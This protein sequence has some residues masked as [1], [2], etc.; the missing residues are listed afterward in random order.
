MMLMET[1]NYVLPDAIPANEYLTIEGKKIS[2]S[3][4]Y[5]IWLKD[6]LENF[7][8]DPLRYTLAANAPETKDTDF[9]WAQFQNRNNDELADI[10]GNFINR[11]LIFIHRYYDGCVSERNKLDNLDEETVIA[12][13]F[14]Q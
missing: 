3:Q 1:G 9:S 6:Y 2:T 10:L 7:P 8:P 12:S 11:T 14:L 4:N 13:L 5:A